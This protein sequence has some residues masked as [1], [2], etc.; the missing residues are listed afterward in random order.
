MTATITTIIVTLALITKA[1]KSLKTLD[2]KD[3][4]EKRQYIRKINTILLTIQ[5]VIGFALVT[6]LFGAG[7]IV[8]TITGLIVMAFG[9]Q[10]DA[11]KLKATK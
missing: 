7:F 11:D 9:I 1:I 3:M 4:E 6:S 5:F 8:A 10:L 2:S